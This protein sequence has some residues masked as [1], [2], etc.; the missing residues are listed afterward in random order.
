[1]LLSIDNLLVRYGAITALHGVSLSIDRGEIVTL[2]GAN[3]A[4]KTT[5]LRTISGLLHPASGTIRWHGNTT[6]TGRQAKMERSEIEGRR[7]TAP[8]SDLRLPT[9]DLRSRLAPPPPPAAPDRPP[10]HQPCSRRPADFCRSLRAR[11]SPLGGYPTEARRKSTPAW[12]GDISCSRCSPNAANSAAA[13]SAAASSRC[14]P[15]AA[16]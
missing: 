16:P 5:L 10:G 9:S 7:S 14:S 6:G 2:I 11:K 3:G 4:G 13:R 8:I 12:N 1:M 15:S